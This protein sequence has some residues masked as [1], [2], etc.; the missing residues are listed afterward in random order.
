MYGGVEVQHPRFIKLAL[1]VRKTS[2]SRSGRFIYS[3]RRASTHKI[4]GYM[5]PRVDVEVVKKRK[6]TIS[7]ENRGSCVIR[8]VTYA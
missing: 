1:C 6:K 3:E 7:A 4:S 2:N 8:A 5:R